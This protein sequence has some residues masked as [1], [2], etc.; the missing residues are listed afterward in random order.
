MRPEFLLA[1][2]G[3]ALF[4]G[5]W[6]IRTERNST[7]DASWILGWTLACLLSI[8]AH[9]Q[10]VGLFPVW[11]MLAGGLVA[12]SSSR[13]V[14]AIGCI[15]ATWIVVAA[16]AQLSTFKF[17]FGCHE[18]PALQGFTEDLT[19]FGPN[20]WPEYSSG[21]SPW[22]E[23]FQRY[24]DNFT[25]KERYIWEYLPGFNAEHVLSLAW[26]NTSISVAVWLNLL[27]SVASVK[28]T[29]LLF[30]RG[31]SVRN[32]LAAFLGSGSTFLAASGAAIL[33]PLV[34]DSNIYFYR[35]HSTHL[36]LVV[37]NAVALSH[38]QLRR[39][40]VLAPL[41][42]AAIALCLQSTVTTSKY[43]DSKFVR[44]WQ[45]SFIST[46]TDWGDVSARVSHLAKAC[47][48]RKSQERIAVDDLTYTALREYPHLLSLTYMWEAQSRIEPDIPPTTAVRKFGTALLA[49]CANFG[50][51]IPAEVMREGDLC[52]ANFE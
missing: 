18:H 16:F 11:L 47:G 21:L 45:G 19:I 43:I 12:R 51:H 32:R 42:C 38:L 17:L 24:A 22:I 20:K 15:A 28:S 30:K 25:F 26:L 2:Q 52:C 37:I 9:P 31:D 50:P 23:K 36:A 6:L 49:K 29:R 44:G 8:Q 34:V 33:L 13:I 35:C 7:L 41:Y 10:G 27:T 46:R 48:F 3:A 1:L 5:Y 4:I 40:S 39:H 14:Q